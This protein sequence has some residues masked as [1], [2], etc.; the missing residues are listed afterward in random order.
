M[1][2]VTSRCWILALFI[3]EDGQRLLLGDGA[4]EFNK[5]QQHFAANKISSTT[6]DVQGNNGVLLAAQTMQ[7]S[8]QTFAGYVGDATM[9]KQQIESYRRAFLNFFTINTM[10]EVIYVLPDGSAVKRQQGFVVKAPS[11]EELWQI[12]PEYSVTM[13]F[14][15]INYYKYEEDAEGN[16]IYGQS[17]TINLS[18]AV[19]G[20][21]EWDE[22]GLVWDA[23]GAVSLPGVNS[24]TVLDIDSNYTVNPIWTVVGPAVNPRL[25]NKT[26]GETLT[27]NG[28][29]NAGETLEINTTKHTANIGTR[30]VIQYVSGDWLGMTKGANTLSYATN[31]PNAPASTIKWTEIVMQ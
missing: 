27:Y 24:D 16:E 19:L 12:H 25:T 10:Y 9:S 30:N 21:Y 3:R 6:I 7:A 20:G 8:N 11:V 28:T 14:E 1:I 22:N 29:V 13:N 15:D 5:K 4:Y 17:A 18:N 31:N 2:N 26:T 23:L